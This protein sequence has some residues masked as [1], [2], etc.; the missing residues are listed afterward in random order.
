MKTNDRTDVRR[1]IQD[2]RA[3]YVPNDAYRKLDEYFRMLL[4]QRRADMADGSASKLRGIVLIG[5]SGSGKTTAIQHLIRSN[6][7]LLRTDTSQEICEL[8]SL[9]VPS[10]A[11]MKFVGTAVLQAAGYP[12]SRDKSASTIWDMVRQQLMFRQTLFLHLDE[13]QDL[14]RFQT[15]NER[16]SVVN[17]LKS[18][19]ENSR[20]PVG[21]ILSG[22]PE[23]KTLIN[24]DPQLARRLYPVE[25]DR[26]NEFRNVGAVINLVQRYTGR[27]GIG[28]NEDLS[29]ENFAQRL[30]HA[31]DYEF[32][33]MAELVVQ[34][35]TMALSRDGLDARLSL[36]HFA[37]VFHMR[38]AA[39]DGLNPFI[40]EDFRRIDPR[41][42]LDH[43][44][45]HS[46][47]DP[48]GPR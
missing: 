10:P 7:E 2:L 48:R 3:A 12:L 8:I 21:L 35:I 26:L 4:E 15:E 19:M 23:F 24:Q 28:I 6:R 34:A 39:V 45:M 33:L 30:I 18:L 42:V 40:A 46:A 14:T 5:R 32:G 44:S 38:S 22:M 43:D 20:W 11:T 29:G 47:D 36:S 9:Q 16:R 31:A 17:T 37:D 13:A 1:I 27:A 41:Q 25:I